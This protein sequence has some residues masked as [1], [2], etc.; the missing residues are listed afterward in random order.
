M[1]VLRRGED[2]GWRPALD[3]TLVLSSELV[4]DVVLGAEVALRLY[5]WLPTSSSTSVLLRCLKRNEEL[6][7][8]AL[9]LYFDFIHSYMILR[10]LSTILSTW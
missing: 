9:E 2:S 8:F 3:S 5:D 6:F 1:A 4:E 7:V 10:F